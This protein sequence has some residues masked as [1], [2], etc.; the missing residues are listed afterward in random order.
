MI[1]RSVCEQGLLDESDKLALGDR[2]LYLGLS[3]L[4]EKLEARHRV[5]LLELE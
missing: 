1:E 2:G 4:I 3:K 5:L